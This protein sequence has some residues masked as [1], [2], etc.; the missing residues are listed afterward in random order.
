M[1]QADGPAIAQRAS[2]AS[3]SAP[4]LYQNRY[5]VDAGR[6]HIKVCPHTTPT[7]PLRALLT[8]CPAR[9]YQLNDKAGWRLPPTAAWN[10]APA[11]SSAVCLLQH[12]RR[13]CGDRGLDRHPEHEPVASRLLHLAGDEDR[14]IFLPAQADG[15]LN[16]HAISKLLPDQLMRRSEREPTDLG[17]RFSIPSASRVLLT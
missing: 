9:C 15:R 13:G 17:G 10:A 5:F 12:P 6:V 11:G 1:P 7:P 8:A 2:P 14:P 16:Q 3:S 4:L